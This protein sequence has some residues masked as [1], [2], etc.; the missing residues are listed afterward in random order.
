[1]ELSNGEAAAMVT[2]GLFCMIL[3]VF[4]VLSATPGALGAASVLPAFS[5]MTIG[6]GGRALI[7]NR[8]RDR[9]EPKVPREYVKC[10]NCGATSSFVAPDDA[11]WKAITPSQYCSECG[12]MIWSRQA[13]E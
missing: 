6:L 2:V 7:R 4:L 12:H 1:M 9:D 11:Y 8:S 5:G 10:G 13:T 3:E